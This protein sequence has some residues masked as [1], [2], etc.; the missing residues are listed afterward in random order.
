MSTGDKNSMDVSAVDGDEVVCDLPDLSLSLQMLRAK[1]W[2]EESPTPAELEGL[3][4]CE[5]EYSHK[6]STISPLGSGA[7]GFVWTAV[8]KEHNKEVLGFMWG[9]PCWRSLIYSSETCNGG[10]DTRIWVLSGYRWK[11]LQYTLLTP[12]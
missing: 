10:G 6:Y 3:A 9:W 11:L 8:E 5:G 2:F 1:P 12:E 4:A 7:F